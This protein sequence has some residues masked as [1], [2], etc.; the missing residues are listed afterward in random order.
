MTTDLVLGRK[1]GGDLLQ[2]RLSKAFDVDQDERG[3]WKRGGKSFSTVEKKEKG[4]HC[5]GRGVISVL[6]LRLKRGRTGR[7]DGE[8]RGGFIAQ[9][10]E[11]K[12]EKKMSLYFGL[13]RKGKGPLHEP[14]KKRKLRDL[15]ESRGGK[16]GACLPGNRKKKKEGYTTDVPSRSKPH[17]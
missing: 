15:S 2:D 7:Q 6:P 10:A 1:G 13:S 16:K 12:E 8:K 17:A 11:K 14:G 3:V 5:V 4:T 9:R